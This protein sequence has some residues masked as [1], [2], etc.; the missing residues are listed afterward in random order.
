MSRS[1]S[2]WPDPELIFWILVAHV[3]PQLKL[4]DRWGARCQILILKKKPD[5]YPEPAP[6]LITLWSGWKNKAQTGLGHRPGQANKEG[7]LCC[8]L[9]MRAKIR[10]EVA[11]FSKQPS[12]E[13]RIIMMV[14]NKLQRRSQISRFRWREIWSD[15]ARLRTCFQNKRLG[16]RVQETGSLGCCILGQSRKMKVLVEGPSAK[17]VASSVRN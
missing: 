11:L 3:L 1:A 12:D 16:T 4:A 17:T 7:E 8:K 2:Y 15:R 6:H 9:Q 10:S 13:R 14:S 5:L